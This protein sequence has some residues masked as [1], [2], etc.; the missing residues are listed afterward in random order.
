MNLSDLVR[1]SWG[2]IVR[3]KVVTLL[4]MIGLS[5]GCAAIIMAISIG[6]STQA[7]SEAEMNRN[8]KM[9]E[10]TVTS[11][12]TGGRGAGQ[13]S[14]QSGQG[15][16]RGAL[17]MQKLDVIRRMAH[18][19]AVSP[20][21]KL[22]YMEMLTLDGKSVSVEVIGT[23]IESLAPFGYKFAKGGVFGTPGSVV[24]NHG[25]MFGLADQKT[26]KEM[27]EKLQKDP[28][29]EQLYALFETLGNQQTELYQQQ[30]HFR[31]GE[32]TASPVKQKVSTPL[33]VS[34]VLQVKD[35]ESEE[36]AVYDKAVYVSIETARMLQE[37]LGI[38]DTAKSRTKLDTV[39]VKVE[40]KAYVAQVEEQLKKL[41]LN[42]Q[43][44]LFQEEM[45]QQKFATYKK[46][47][48]GIGVFIL[49]L[50][51]LSIFV[52]MT[53]STH[54]RRRQI[55]VMKILGANLWQIRQIFLT[56]AAALGLMGGAAGMTISY[57][58]VWGVNKFIASGT[59]GLGPLVVDIPLNALPVGVAFAVMTGILSGIYPAISASRTNALEVIKNG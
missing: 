54:Q 17:T 6:Q 18:V 1:M 41:Y 50:A 40:S 59:L 28:Y 34:G 37:Q 29:N 30:I 56:E 47:A 58:V 31:S 12:S 19:T 5:V 15:F 32:A 8:Y 27:N 52:A 51:S 36:Y 55:G 57:L 42:T 23:D 14:A 48:L 22:S 35:G 43:S 24:V 25:A 45:I 53:M 20:L 16:E 11:D 46:I 26:L 3:R 13:G 44:N 39:M 21:L 2:Q 49:L 9:D 33:R 4:C 7:Y 38:G 10:I